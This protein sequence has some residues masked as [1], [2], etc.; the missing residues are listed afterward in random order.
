[1]ELTT[2]LSSL[3]F[4]S[5]QSVSPQKAPI[6]DSIPALCTVISGGLIT[7]FGV[8]V[9][10]LFAGSVLATIGAGLIYTIDI[11]TSSSKWIGYQALSGI[12]IGFAFQVPMIANQAFVKMS[13]I[14]SVTA[15][16]LCK[17]SSPSLTSLCLP[18]PVFQTIGGAFFVSAGQTAFAN[19]LLSRI[20]ITAPGVKPGLV[21]AT[22]ATQLRD[23]FA[24]ED[25]DGI[26]IAYMDG[27]KLTFALC[28][29]FA[30]VTLPIALF[31]KW[32]NIKPKAEAVGAV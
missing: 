31:A 26:L 3:E 25:I 22:G 9:P 32:Q 10:W 12:G 13:E 27:L 15:I 8:Y 24:A 18:Y 1:M 20:P 14:S 21:V 30:G 4:V 2:S 5:P 6:A 7:A 28:I 11:G 23:V 19:R 16:T 17:L 29:A